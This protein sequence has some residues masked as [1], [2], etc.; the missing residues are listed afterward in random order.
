MALQHEWM[1]EQAVKLCSHLHVTLLCTVLQDEW[2]REQT[3]KRNS[4][5]S[6]GFKETE[7]VRAK[8]QEAQEEL[9]ATRASLAAAEKAAADADKALNRCALLQQ[10]SHR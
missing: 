6:D 10:P 4:T 2:M 5:M 8:L 3:L 7:S 1:H 9:E